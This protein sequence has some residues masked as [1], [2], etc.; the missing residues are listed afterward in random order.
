MNAANRKGVA[1]RLHAQRLR[2]LAAAIL[3]GALLCGCA[4]F[5]ALKGEPTPA[6]ADVP[7]AGEPSSAEPPITITPVPID[8]MAEVKGDKP[9]PPGKGAIERI[10]CLNGEER[11]H[12]RISLEARGGQVTSF[13]YYSR[14][15]AFTSRSI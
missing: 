4:Q 9:L 14:W 5:P 2:G 15:Q 1:A 3:A 7:A 12:A 6:E 13:A 10:D 8:P 11:L